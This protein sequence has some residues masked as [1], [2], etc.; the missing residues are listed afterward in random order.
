MT[1]NRLKEGILFFSLIA[2]CF[3]AYAFFYVDT[4]PITL[5]LCCVAAIL[6]IGVLEL[7]ENRELF[8]R[9]QILIC[10]VLILLIILEIMLSAHGDL[11]S[12]SLYIFY[13][14]TFSVSGYK[15]SSDRFHKKLKPV[16]IFYT[17]LSV[18]GIYQFIAYSFDLPF[19]EFL[20][21]GFMVEGFNRTNLV[22]IAGHTFQR[23]HSIYL[24]PSTLSQFGAFAIILS[25][26]LYNKKLIKLRSCIA[27]IA[28]NLI[29][30]VLSVAGTGFLMLGVL[31]V[32][33]YIVYIIKHGLNEKV[34]AGFLIILAST[35]GVLFIDSPLTEYIRVRV[36]EVIDPKYS[37]GMRFSY[38]YIIM[39]DAWKSN[40]FGMTPGNEFIAI[41]NYFDKIGAPSTF[42][43]MASGYA[44]I[45]VELGLIGLIL[46]FALMY[47]VKHKDASC[48]YIFVF[49]L[50]INF[51]GGNLLQNYFWI[52]VM[53][54]NVKFTSAAKCT[55][56]HSER[57]KKSNNASRKKLALD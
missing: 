12:A 41:S 34:A 15:S 24:E 36:Y 37:G 54:L 48:R 30:A 20:I 40:F 4:F 16:M 21:E 17:A 39:F 13:I 3:D 26:I 55:E 10:L 31:I 56:R 35:L 52:F 6:V 23:A 38:P 25:I 44:K 7:F 9:K 28:L 19:K 29:A 46:L 14:L 43:T 27:I 1:L 42:S 57:L 18:Y 33:Y 47:T 11:A 50:C 22:Y 2:L 8:N 32:Y 51:V 53:L 49:M 5:S 45:G